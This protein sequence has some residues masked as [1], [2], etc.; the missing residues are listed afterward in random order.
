MFDVIRVATPIEK[1]GKTLFKKKSK[2]Y[3]PN[4]FPKKYFNSYLILNSNYVFKK[5]KQVWTNYQNKPF[6]YWVWSLWLV[7]LA[8]LCACPP[9]FQQTILKDRWVKTEAINHRAFSVTNAPLL[10]F[11]CLLNSWNL[12]QH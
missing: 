1:R 10:I 12:S 2:I 11:Y 5:V 7:A 9:V 8:R 3:L 4:H 6:F